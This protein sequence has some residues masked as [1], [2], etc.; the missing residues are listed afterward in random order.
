MRSDPGRREPFL[1]P[2]TSTTSYCEPTA[3]PADEKRALYLAC[4]AGPR[5]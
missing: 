4:F 3:A 2:S 5:V 1:L